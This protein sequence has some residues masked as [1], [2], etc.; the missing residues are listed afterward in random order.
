MPA[1]VSLTTGNI[2]PSGELHIAS[3]ELCR[4]ALSLYNFPLSS[5]SSIGLNG[6]YYNGVE[7]D[8]DWPKGCYY[9]DDTPSCTDGVWFNEHATGAASDNAKVL[10]SP[11]LTPI[12]ADPLLFVGDSDIDYWRNTESQFSEGHSAIYNV[13]FGGYT[14]SDVK[15]EVTS[16]TATF[17]PKTV[18][19]V[20]GEND[21]AGGASVSS[22]YSKFKE[23]VQAYIDG[24]AEKV[25]TVSTKP[26]PETTSLHTK[27]EELD[28]LIKSDFIKT[29]DGK[30]VFIDSYNAFLDVGNT[31]DL[32]ADDGLH[33]SDK[34]YEHWNTW[35]ATTLSDV[36]GCTL[37]KSNECD[38]EGDDVDDGGG[39][40]SNLHVNAG[41]TLGATLGVVLAGLE[42]V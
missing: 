27:Y 23:V 1:G 8:S 37:W 17:A 19:L 15:P 33:L 3:G 28:G 9:C 42:L 11:D 36:T 6:D 41:V 39:G 13:G 12:P 34:G 5:S 29:M 16:F 35:V 25:I 20:C 40:A 18:V 24:G 32:Y 10:C 30:F 38:E 4:A 31:R 21:L 22:T 26:E 14:C 7:D 2:C